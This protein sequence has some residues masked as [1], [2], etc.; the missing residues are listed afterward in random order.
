MAISVHNSQSEVIIPESLID[1]MGFTREVFV[2]GREKLLPL[3]YRQ[4]LA[5]F[6]KPCKPSLLIFF[7]GTGSVGCDNYKQCRI[8]APPLVRFFK[9]YPEEKCIV[10]LPQC[11]ANCKWVNVP[12]NL[13]DHKM[14]ENP[15]FYMKSAMALLEEK[16]REFDVDQK[17]IFASGISMGGFATWDIAA[18]NPQRFAGLFPICGGADLSKAELLKDMKIWCVH[19]ELDKTVLTLR[20]RNMVQALKE[21]GNTQVIYDEVAGAAHNSWDHAFSDDRALEYLFGK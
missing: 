8:A 3:L 5:N 15:S 11:P 19:G 6:D 2:S 14:P 18:R 7:H 17:R 16:I 9:K 1:E 12:W 10:L 13:P 4:Y 21:A 20:S